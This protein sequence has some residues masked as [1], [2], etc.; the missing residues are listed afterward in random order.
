MSAPSPVLRTF[1]QLTVAPVFSAAV[2][3]AA[4]VHPVG[5]HALPVP[6][7]VNHRFFPT[8]WPSVAA[9]PVQSPASCAATSRCCRRELGAAPRIPSHAQPAPARCQPAGSAFLETSALHRQVYA[10]EP[11]APSLYCWLIVPSR[12]FAAC[13]PYLRLRRPSASL[14]TIVLVPT[15]IAHDLQVRPFFAQCVFVALP[16]AAAQGSTPSPAQP[17]RRCIGVRSRLNVCGLGLL[18]VTAISTHVERTWPREHLSPCT[19]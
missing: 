2:P 11:Q 4:L 8:R 1:L 13:V 5:A 18:S 19:V 6:V 12:C 9:R 7:C 3:T 17:Q 16:H 10:S 15:R 14:H